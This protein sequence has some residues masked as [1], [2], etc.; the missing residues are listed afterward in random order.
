MNP[1]WI[2]QSLTIGFYSLAF[3]IWISTAIAILLMGDRVSKRSDSVFVIV[4]SAS[5]FF[6]GAILTYLRLSGVV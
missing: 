4:C 2:N 1:E 3:A 6:G 5:A